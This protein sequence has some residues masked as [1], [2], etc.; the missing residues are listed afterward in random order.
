MMSRFLRICLGILCL[1]VVALPAAAQGI[2]PSTF[3]GWTAS[4]APTVIPP[5][6]LDSLLGPDAA[7]FREYV[8]KSA[9]QRTYSQGAQTAT[10][11]LYRMRDPSSAYGAYTFLLNDSLSTVPVG[12]YASAS[13]DRALIVVGEMLM[14][15]STPPKKSRPPD[16]DLKQLADLLD[17]KADHTPYPFVGEH[18]P[19]Q[20]RVPGSVR[21]VIGPLGLAHFVPLGTDDWIG[22]DHSAETILARYRVGGKD[23]TLLVSSYPT[24]QIAAEKF[25]GMLRRFVFDPPGGVSPDQTV[26][27]GK[28]VSSFVAVVVGAPSR[29]AANKV[30]DQVQYESNV[31]WNEP[32]QTLTE[33]S[34]NS[35]IVGAFLG[36]G[37]IMILAIAAGIGFGGLRVLVKIFLPNK[38]FDREKEIEILQLGISSKPIKA[39]DFY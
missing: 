22:F 28:R 21:Y 8:V 24:Q 15:V 16:A 10:I 25:A 27:F 17:K 36:T 7:A 3:A 1:A 34:I 33:P 11:T 18:L 2:L 14:D 12:S 26:L 30:L 31:T 38:V 29:Q 9:E 13:R 19:E 23:E 20:G 37:A 5:T 32:H 35:M 4:G 39:K 6:G